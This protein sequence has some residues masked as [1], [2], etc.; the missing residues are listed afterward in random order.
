MKVCKRSK[1]YNVNDRIIKQQRK[2]F[3]IMQTVNNS[4]PETKINAPAQVLLVCRGVFEVTNILRKKKTTV[5]S[6]N[7]ITTSVIPV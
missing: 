6:N 2:T 1:I 7:K 3:G 5:L 4:Q